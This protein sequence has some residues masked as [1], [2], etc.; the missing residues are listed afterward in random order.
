MCVSRCVSGLLQDTS[1]CSASLSSFPGLPKPL[2]D[3]VKDSAQGTWRQRQIL[4]DFIEIYKQ[5]WNDGKKRRVYF[6]GWRQEI[7][8]GRWYQTKWCFWL[9]TLFNRRIQKTEREW[10]WQKCLP[11]ECFEG[12]RLLPLAFKCVQYFSI[13][14]L[15][16][17]EFIN[18]M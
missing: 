18:L 12:S 10:N 8:S 2:K 16:F 15:M 14:F 6:P 1:W 4:Y 13:S 3:W 7:V 9:L 17:Q 11:Q 5:V